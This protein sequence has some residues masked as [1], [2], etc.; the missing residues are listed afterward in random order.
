MKYFDYIKIIYP[1][2]KKAL[3]VST[4]MGG[5]LDGNKHLHLGCSAAR[6]HHD[7]PSTLSGH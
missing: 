1:L 3:H 6:Q 2:G 4:H 5:A 7:G